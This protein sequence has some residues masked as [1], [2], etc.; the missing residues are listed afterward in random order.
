[1]NPELAALW[2]GLLLLVVLLDNPLWELWKNSQSGFISVPPSS[3]LINVSNNTGPLQSLPSRGYH[4]Q[5]ISCSNL[6]QLSSTHPLECDGIQ[7]SSTCGDVPMTP[8]LCTTPEKSRF[9]FDA[10]FQQPPG[11]SQQVCTAFDKLEDFS[12]GAFSPLGRFRSP[13]SNCPL[14]DLNPKFMH[15]QFKGHRI[16]FV[17]DSHA[18]NLFTAF[19]AEVRNQRL[20]VERHVDVDT[21]DLLHPYQVYNFNAELDE[22]KDCIG[23]TKLKPCDP[24]S[25]CC[26]VQVVYVW[27]AYANEYAKAIELD[28]PKI[29]PTLVVT[30]FLSSAYAGELGMESSLTSLFASFERFFLQPPRTTKLVIAPFPLFGGEVTYSKI[31]LW[32]AGE[33]TA[34]WSRNALLLNQQ[35][36]IDSF[37]RSGGALAQ[38]AK[39]SHTVCA[40]YG[41]YSLKPGLREQDKGGVKITGHEPC[42]ASTD[43]AI[44]RTAITFALSGGGGDR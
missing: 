40:L 15:D 34:Q 39:L 5:V 44:V 25:G 24:E 8:G 21:K 3:P 18:R 27:A 31:K 43:R 38:L 13:N 9:E 4:A 20:V 26:G 19:V 35:H 2:L 10:G 29:A 12:L 37:R 1:M 6:H 11:N 32:L 36:F 28:L 42:V 22:F 23:A 33:S 17:G 14:V 30:D 16:V 7:T 41:T